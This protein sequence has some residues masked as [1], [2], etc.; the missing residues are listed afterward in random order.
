M[1]KLTLTIAAVAALGVAACSSEDDT[2]TT[3]DA[4]TVED[5]A[6]ETMESVDG[7][8]ASIEAD[9][10]EAMAEGEKAADKIGA[11]MDQEAAE[12]AETVSEEA[13]N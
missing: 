3:V 10:D 9:I 4:G 12:T 11:E 7:M 2:A 5:N 6:A 8:E 1:K 13:A